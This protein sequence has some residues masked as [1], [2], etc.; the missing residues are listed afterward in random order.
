MIEIEEFLTPKLFERAYSEMLRLQD[1]YNKGTPVQRDR[2]HSARMRGARAARARAPRLMLFLEKAADHLQ[3]QNDA[4]KSRF[5]Q[6]GFEGRRLEFSEYGQ[7]RLAYEKALDPDAHEG[8][9]FSTFGW[10]YSG[11]MSVLE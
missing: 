4:Q 9:L 7:M 11:C 6:E 10:V 5:A 2:A 1:E 3:K 8:V